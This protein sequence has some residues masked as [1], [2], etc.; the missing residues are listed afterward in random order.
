MRDEEIYLLA[1]GF[2]TQVKNGQWKVYLFGSLEQ[3]SVLREALKDELGHC[4]HASLV[5]A[6]HLLEKRLEVPLLAAQLLPPLFVLLHTVSDHLP[7]YLTLNSLLSL[8]SIMQSLL[9]RRQPV[10]TVVYLK[11]YHLLSLRLLQFNYH[12]PQKFFLPLQGKFP[13]Q[14]KT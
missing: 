9:Q 10:H 14:Q 5:I 2:G 4:K 11:R 6:Q 1:K 7:R 8:Q 3:L 13:I 12:L